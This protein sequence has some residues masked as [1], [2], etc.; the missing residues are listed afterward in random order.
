MR[1]LLFCVLFMRNFFLCCELWFWC[2][3]WWIVLRVGCVDDLFWWCGCC[4]CC[5]WLFVDRSWF[6][7]LCWLRWCLCWW[8]F[9]FLLVKF[10]RW[11]CCLCFWCW[12]CWLGEVVFLYWWW[13]W[14][15]MLWCWC[16]CCRWYFVCWCWVK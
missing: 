1:V 14:V 8:V 10:W 4:V 12:V 15:L 16:W 9:L 7:G 6:W 11:V 2:F 3:F 5:F 13:L